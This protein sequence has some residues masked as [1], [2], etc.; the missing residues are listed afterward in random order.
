MTA[1]HHLREQFTSHKVE[2]VESNI[3]DIMPILFR[4]HKHKIILSYARVIYEIC[5]IIIR[6]LR[7]PFINSRSNILFHSNIKLQN[8]GNST[9]RLYF[10]KNRLSGNFI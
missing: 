7:L 10:F 8:G 5:N 3:Y 9:N 1:H 6:M 4:H 2:T